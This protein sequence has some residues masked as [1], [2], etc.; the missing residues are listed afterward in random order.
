MKSCSSIF[1]INADAQVS[2]ESG[3]SRIKFLFLSSLKFKERI[4]HG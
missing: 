3:L 4:N 1:F 2:F